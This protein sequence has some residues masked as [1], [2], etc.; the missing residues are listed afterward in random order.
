MW[1]NRI[2]V[3]KIKKRLKNFKA[4]TNIQKCENN[5]NKK[6]NKKKT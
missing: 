4:F 1:L 6:K 3:K 2:L 5:N